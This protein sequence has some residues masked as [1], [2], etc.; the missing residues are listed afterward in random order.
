MTQKLLERSLRGVRERPCPRLPS[1]RVRFGGILGACGR[2]GQHIPGRGGER[3]GRPCEQ[4][5]ALAPSAWSWGRSLARSPAL[6]QSLAFCAVTFPEPFG[7]PAP[8]RA[9][10]PGKFAFP[11]STRVG[12]APGSED[13]AC[14]GDSGGCG[15]GRKAA[16]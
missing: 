12:T 13:S 16:T 4:L 15:P 2:A 9:V 6:S 3:G 8:A 10:A 1:L 11:E 14:P 5:A 7:E